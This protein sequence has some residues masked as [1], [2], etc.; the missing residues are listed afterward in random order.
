[1]AHEPQSE[2]QQQDALAGF[3]R[4]EDLPA[5]RMDLDFQPSP[6]E[7]HPGLLIR[8]TYRF[9]DT[10]LIIPHYLLRLL[11][12]FDGSHTRGQLFDEIRRS[13][14]TD[15]ALKLEAHLRETL[16]GAGFLD[17]ERHRANRESVMENFRRSSL[18]SAAHAGAAYPGTREEIRGYFDEN[19]SAHRAESNLN[20]HNLLAVAAPHI[21]FEGGWQSYA[22]MIPA[23]QKA[24]PDSLFVVMG[25][26]HYGDV[27]RFGLTAKA[28]ETPL[29]I[30]RPEPHLVAELASASPDAT[31]IEDYCHAIDHSLEFHVL[32]LQHLVRPDVRVL[33][34]LVGGFCDALQSGS[35]PE[36]SEAMSRLFAALRDIAAKRGT[37][38]FWMLSVDMA[39]MGKRYGDRFEV[40]ASQGKML[41][42]EEADRDRVALLGRADSAKFWDHVAAHDAEMKWCG[43]STL[44]SFTQIYP[45]AR[46]QLLSYQQWNID[47]T[48]VVS[49]GTV[50]FQRD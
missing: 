13:A 45:E 22:A 12:F 46:A 37:E 21:S 33:P 19:L 15:A 8:D 38:L 23:L 24:H 31:V 6:S 26:S 32:L 34:I 3:P 25:T 17:G 28:F 2:A 11:K 48:S 30:T 43:S 10:T 16:D 36:Q 1:M 18:R 44:Y 9:S 27:D 29:G 50:A 7:E 41:E 14:G 39:H 42:I 47:P 40:T 49:F 20:G 35:R 5:L 4:D